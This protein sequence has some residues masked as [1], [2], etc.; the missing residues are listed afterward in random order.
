MRRLALL[1]ALVA[2]FAAVAFASVSRAAAVPLGSLA[3]GPAAA[4]A[5]APPPADLDA[6]A[7]RPAGADNAACTGCHRNPTLEMTLGSGEKLPLTV[8][9]SAFAQS[10]HDQKG[11]ACTDCHKEITGFPHPKLTAQD[12]RQV[13]LDLNAS[14]QGCH[15]D[16]VDKVKDSVHAVALAKGD[17]Q[18]AVCTDCHGAH[19][20]KAVAS[21]PRAA[22]AV[23]CSGCHAAIYEKFSTSVHGA[24]LLQGNPDVPACADCHGVHSIP[25]PTTASFRLKSPTQMCGTCHTDAT[26]M[27]R[28]GLSTQVLGTYVSDFHGTTV[29]LFSKQSPDQQTNKPVCFDCHGVHDIKSAKDPQGGLAIKENL[30]QTCQKC[31]PDASA[32]F[33]ASWMSHYTP[34]A[35][36]TPLVFAVNLF[37]KVAIP[38]ILGGM[39]ALIFLDI[40]RRVAGGHR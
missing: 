22:S 21:Q 30:Q 39:G 8:D 32:N 4:P 31:H 14:C 23:A 2:F 26:K 35:Q 18:A 25:D 28:Y 34:S 36:K 37:Y 16:K 9:L 20:T 15:Q 13:T 3:A 17:R 6:P 27:A 1:G 40:G 19:E 24:A 29:A 11:V 10:I 5:A 38:T 33:P 12:R 7:D